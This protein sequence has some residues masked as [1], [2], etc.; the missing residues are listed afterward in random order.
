MSDY[1]SSF[2]LEALVARDGETGSEKTQYAQP[3]LILLD[4]LMPG[5]DGFETCRRL[6]ADETLRDVPVIFVT[7]LTNIEDK[8]KGF[9]LGG[10]D[11]ITKPFQQDEVLA[12]VT[13]H[14]L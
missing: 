6:K 2:G 14:H 11:Y 12:R 13:T 4:V 9:Q 5:L 3:D 1:L 8:V 7:A 10:V